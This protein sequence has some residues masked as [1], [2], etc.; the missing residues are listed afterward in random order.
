M[1]AI[2]G[3]YIA[4]VNEATRVSDIP[5]RTS[6]KNESAV[7]KRP[8]GKGKS[9]AENK[10]EKPPC[11][12]CTV[13]GHWCGCIFAALYFG[14][15]RGTPDASRDSLAQAPALAGSTQQ[16]SIA[17]DGEI[18]P[19]VGRGQHFT[20]GNVRYCYFQEERLKIMK[21]DVRGPRS[22]VGVQPSCCRL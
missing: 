18:V 6:A 17:A 14:L 20:L 16:G 13:R 15:F 7:A 8:V 3:R 9:R 10:S 21:P 12:R 5:T 2:T 1:E 4:P 11:H 19:A 22:H